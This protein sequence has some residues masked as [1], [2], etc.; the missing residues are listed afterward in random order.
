M[1]VVPE[2]GRSF[3]IHY[4]SVFDPIESLTYAAALTSKIRL[5]TSV[6]DVL[7]HAPV[8]L[9]KRLATLDQLSHG[10]VVAG[11][12]Q[13][14][15]A[16]EFRAANIPQSRRGRGFEEFIEAMKASWGPDPVS[17]SGRVYQIEESYIGPKPV[18]PGGPKILVG[19]SAPAALE[20]AGRIADGFNPVAGDQVSLEAN[21]ALFRDAALAA[22]REPT[23]LPVVVRAN[24]QLA[25]TNTPETRFLSGTIEK[26]IEDAQRVRTLNVDEIFFDF[27]ASAAPDVQLDLMKQLIRLSD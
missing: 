3:P 16:E 6:M 4:R 20:R 1:P 22:G 8:I 7:F 9:G 21:I 17:F 25:A 13:G 5:G 11:L 26:I 19:S 10:R 18:Q 24:S 27:G 14:H 12:G 15:I 23:E 2:S